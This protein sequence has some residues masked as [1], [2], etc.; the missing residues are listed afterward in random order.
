MNPNA[1]TITIQTALS[2]HAPEVLRGLPAR[3]DYAL[4]LETSI[5]GTI[6]EVGTYEDLQ[7]F[8]LCGEPDL[9]ALGAVTVHDE[10]G[11]TLYSADYLRVAVE[12][13]PDPMTAEDIEGALEAFF[14]PSL[15][16]ES[17]TA[18]EIADACGFPLALTVLGLAGLLRSGA[19]TVE[20]REGQAV[21][22]WGR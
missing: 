6:G 20:V 9:Y 17:G 4:G 15:G 7:H 16:D 11:V 5:V 8:D 18:P 14:D 10:D 19:A 3:D 22:S 1:P 21:Y 12:D 13:L 2:T